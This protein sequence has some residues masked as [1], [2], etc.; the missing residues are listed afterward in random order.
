MLKPPPATRPVGKGGAPKPRCHSSGMQSRPTV[1]ASRE[2]SQPSF[3]GEKQRSDSTA[4]RVGR[5]AEDSDEKS[6][7]LSPEQKPFVQER[8]PRKQCK[9]SFAPIAQRPSRLRNTAVTHA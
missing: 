1:S 9:T 2:T 3:L 4:L 5:V 6:V 8:G 7:P